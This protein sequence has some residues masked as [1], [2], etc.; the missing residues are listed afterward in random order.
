MKKYGKISHSRRIK[1]VTRYSVCSKSSFEIN[2]INDFFVWFCANDIIPSLSVG[3][4]KSEFN[5]S[6]YNMLLVCIICW[7]IL[8]FLKDSVAFLKISLSLLSIYLVVKEDWSYVK[9]SEYSKNVGIYWWNKWYLACIT[10]N[11]LHKY[12]PI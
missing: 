3:K 9:G 2:L 7:R 4:L 5:I 8:T 6:C 12:L 1:T 11:L 10:N